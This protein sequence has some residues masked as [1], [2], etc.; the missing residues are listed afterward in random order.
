MENMSFSH[1]G[2]EDKLKIKGFLELILE[3]TMKTDLSATEHSVDDYIDLVEC[4]QQLLDELTVFV[5]ECDAAMGSDDTNKLD[6]EITNIIKQLVQQ[7]ERNKTKAKGM[8]DDLKKG[9]RDLSKEKSINSVYAK[10]AYESG[11]MFNSKK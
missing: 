10:D 1:C 9:M 5:A 6:E 3:R 11:S 8:M 7:E 2:Y 4:R